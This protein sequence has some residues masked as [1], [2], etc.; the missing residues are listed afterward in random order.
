VCRSS[1]RQATYRG[2]RDTG[3]LHRV[4]PIS[5]ERVSTR[6]LLHRVAQAP[7]ERPLIR[8]W[9]YPVQ[10]E[11]HLAWWGGDEA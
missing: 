9:F 4:K 5:N 7:N 11:R 2:F 10:P 6:A 8:D 3:G 1:M